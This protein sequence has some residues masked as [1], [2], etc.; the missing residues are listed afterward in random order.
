LLL[1][2]ALEVSVSKHSRYGAA[3]AADVDKL[4]ITPGMAREVHVARARVAEQLQSAVIEQTAATARAW[5][6]LQARR[7]AESEAKPSVSSATPALG[8]TQC[9]GLSRTISVRLMSC[10]PVCAC[11]VD[12]KVPSRDTFEVL[13][14]ASVSTL[15][16]QWAS[17]SGPA[18]LPA[19]VTEMDA[20]VVGSTLGWVSACAVLAPAV[21]QLCRDIEVGPAQQLPGVC[22]CVCRTLR[23]DAPLPAAALCRS[24][25]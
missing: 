7:G 21:A 6:A 25:R 22:M 12:V 2:L 11:A 17:G 5:R 14:V 18:V 1:Q 13:D 4:D 15:L 10:C 23:L 20:F 19:H 3:S 8:R 24:R 16:S 9:A